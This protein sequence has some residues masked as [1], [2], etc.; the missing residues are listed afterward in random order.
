[1][2][3]LIRKY[4]SSKADPQEQSRL[5][6]WMRQ[7]DNLQTFNNEKKIWEEEALKGDML[8]ESQYQWNK[9]QKS[10]LIQSHTRLQQTSLHLKYFKY[11][12]AVLLLLTLGSTSYFL[13]LNDEIGGDFYTEVVAPEGQKTE[14]ILPDQSHVKLNGGTRI[15]YANNFGLQNRTL[16]LDGEAYFD[17]TKDPS[18]AFVVQTQKVS[19]KV[20]GTSF[21]VRAYAEDPTVEVGLK[22][23][24]I[25]IEQ[26]TR[27]VMRMKPNDFVVLDKT[28]NTLHRET[29]SIDAIS[30]WTKDELVFEEKSF[31]DITQYLE[32]WYG[33]QVELA[34]E[35]IDNQLYT[36]KVKTESLHEVLELIN[37]LK[38]IHYQIDG[39]KVRINK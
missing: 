8:L 21:N 15:R 14:I 12:A 30:A 4:L 24:S 17:V 19:V 22:E 27:E 18:S 10:L 3:E 7:G 1:M 36:F 16:E 25:G 28:T 11:A 34:P 31:A 39:Q 26:N 20:Y 33:V 9:I 13:T 2:K 32:R 35:L 23:G 5:L 37:V 6:D 29:E 38:P